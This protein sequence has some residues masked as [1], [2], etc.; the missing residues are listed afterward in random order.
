MRKG[1]IIGIVIGVIIGALAVF[2]SMFALRSARDKVANEKPIHPIVGT[3]RTDAWDLFGATYRFDNNG[4][5]TLSFA[6]LPMR[7]M[8]GSATHD[9]TGTW[10]VNDKTLVMKNKTS[11]TPVT[12]VGE[13]ESARIVSVS[14]DDLV[15]ENVNRRGKT[16]RITFYRL[17][18]FVAGETDKPAIIGTWMSV[19]YDQPIEFTAAGEVIFSTDPPQ[20]GKWSQSGGVLRMLIDPAPV[21]SAA[22]RAAQAQTNQT[23]VQMLEV[24][25]GADNNTMTLKPR[26]MPGDPVRSY[27]RA[28]EQDKQRAAARPRNSGPRN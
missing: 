14:D 18:P 23:I 3:W 7:T 25:F 21:R 4:S 24:R 5:F 1:L 26:D 15:L 2:V 13:E 27:R 17:K 8:N 6:D 20:T 28:T 19:P 10:T 12:Q 16:E 11:N 22:R 9:A